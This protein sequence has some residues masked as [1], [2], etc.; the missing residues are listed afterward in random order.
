MTK[1]KKVNKNYSEEKVEFL[2]ECIAIVLPVGEE[3]WNRE[4]E[5]QNANYPER[6]RDVLSI[7]RKFQKL[8]R[9]IG[10][11]FNPTCHKNVREARRIR[12]LIIEK[13]DAGNLTS[14]SEEVNKM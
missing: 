7:R 10:G 13:A 3:D 9:K 4:L 11:S 1:R 2:L 5:S 12:N 8:Y 14:E 6:N